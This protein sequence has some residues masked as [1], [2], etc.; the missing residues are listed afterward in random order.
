M[1]RKLIK[2]NAKQAFR[3]RYWPIV[4]IE[5]LAGVLAGSG[6]TASFSSNLNNDNLKQAMDQPV[7]REITIAALW[8]GALLALAGMAYLFLFGNVIRVGISGIRLS[9][10]RQQGFQFR[11]L[12][13]YLKQYG[14]IVGAMALTTLNIMIGIFIF[15][16]PGIIAAYGLF[17]VPFLLAENPDLTPMET[18]RRSWA[19]MKGFK[20]KLFGLHLSFF[21][22][23]VLTVLTFG[24]LA[25]FYTGPYMALSEAGF[26]L[27]RQQ[28]RAAE[29]IADN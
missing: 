11:D 18:M 20:G 7:V 27:E 12:F 15:I 3:M 6:S 16:V 10:Y 5:L 19:D 23:I 24:V 8:I 17:E 1:D 26:Y 9:A 21:G 14:R 2:Q 22:W 25:A 13:K 29:Q 28:M 4:G